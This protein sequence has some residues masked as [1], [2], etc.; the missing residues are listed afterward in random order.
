M[1]HCLKIKNSM[2]LFV[3]K[4]TFNK[5]LPDR[6]NMKLNRTYFKFGNLKHA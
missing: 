1:N 5:Q 3:R 4:S 6:T 2:V